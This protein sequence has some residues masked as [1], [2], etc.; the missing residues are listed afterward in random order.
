[1]KQ[2]QALE[3]GKVPQMDLYEEEPSPVSRVQTAAPSL[4]KRTTDNIYEMRRE[5]KNKVR[6]ERIRFF[7]DKDPL[8]KDKSLESFSFSGANTMEEL[9][10]SNKEGSNL[11][12]RPSF[13]ELLDQHNY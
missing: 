2:F 8:V 13:E 3:D 4:V 11:E 1:M 7:N 5:K 6:P 12:H 9:V 10:R